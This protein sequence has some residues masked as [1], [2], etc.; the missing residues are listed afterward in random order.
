[1]LESFS[2]SVDSVDQGKW[3][4][5]TVAL[6]IIL[7]QSAF[8]QATFFF[9]NFD[10]EGLD[11]PVFDAAGNRLSGDNYVAVLYGGPTQDSLV[12]ANAGVGSMSP[13]PFTATFGGQAGYFSRAGQLYLNNVLQLG[14]AWLQVRAWDTRLGATYDDVM[15]LGVGGYGQSALFYTYGGD[16][17]ATGRPSQPLRGLESF[18]LV[19]EPSTWTLLA[20]GV[21]ILF[22]KG[23]SFRRST[24]I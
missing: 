5:R 4:M 20:L 11:A 2:G 8:S 9:R 19:P 10:A 14:Y 3:R 21:G 22:W 15:R 16:L 23:N 24:R 6:L 1:V 17:I 13:V 18:S 7:A 12:L